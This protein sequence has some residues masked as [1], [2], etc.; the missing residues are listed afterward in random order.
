[1][2]SI[3]IP[4][5]VPGIY[6]D[7]DSEVYH[8]S[9]GISSTGI[10]KILDCPAR[11]YFEYVTKR[12]RRTPASITKEAAYFRFGRAFHELL[13][14][15]EKFNSH[16]AVFQRPFNKKGL[17]AHGSSNLYK[18]ALV[19]FEIE[20][21]GRQVIETSS[22]EDMT[23]MCEVVRKHSFWT[24][25][26]NPKFEQS[27]F[28]HN[29]MYRTPLRARPDLFD[30]TYCIDM[31]TVDKIP[32]WQRTAKANGYMRQ[33]ALQLDGLK[34][35]DNKN[36]FFGFFLVEKEEPY[37]T[38]L[39]TPSKEDIDEGREEYLL[40]ANLY[41]ECLRYNVWPGYPETFQLINT[42]RYNQEANND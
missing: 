30:D 36:R 38:A 19:N 24:K 14:E 20:A 5:F 7:M 12:S 21:A 33:A 6:A 35:I 31:K 34:T 9:P 2:I 13:L 41:S 40:G 23:L 22:F 37:L 27:I 4:G 8:S 28:F 1:M 11:Y 16:F 25:L 42:R 18:E 29:G 3:D 26:R 10:N 15:P 17:P 39:Y 32:Q